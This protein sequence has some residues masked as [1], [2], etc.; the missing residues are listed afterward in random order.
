MEESL[1]TRAAAAYRAGDPAL[2]EKLARDACEADPQDE[3][4]ALLLSGL[5]LHRHEAREAAEFLRRLLSAGLASAAAKSNLALCYSRLGEHAEAADWARQACREKPSLVSAW[6][7]LGNALLA[8]G[9]PVAA[10][11]ELLQG[12]S[13]NPDHP[14]LILLLGHA[15]RVQGRETEAVSSYRRFEAAS[16]RL[17]EEAEAM[18]LSGRL[19]EAEHRYR[20]LVQAQPA[21]A[22]AHAGLGRALLRLDRTEEAVGALSRALKLQPNDPASRHFLRVARGEPAAGAEPAY[23]KSLFDS[24]ADKFDRSLVDDLGYRIPGE[25][26]EILRGCNGDLSEVVD[27][28]CGTGLVAKALAE[29]AVAIDGVDLS[30][31]ML[32]IARGSERYRNLFEADVVDFL[33][34]SATTYTTAIAADVLVYVGDLNPLLAALARRLR[35]GGCFAFSIELAEGDAWSLNAKTGRYQHSPAAVDVMLS[36]HGFAPAEWTITTIRS[37]LSARI[38]GAIGVCQRMPGEAGP[39]R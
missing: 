11:A 28:G 19:V 30:P 37:E 26:A 13:T 12:L 34:T 5:L 8:V 16:D 35:A 39:R 7:V 6:N 14:A 25:L 36:E 31:R 18:A 23:V 20:Q 3:S 9:D 4:A 15:R 17:L 1:S 10:E 33:Q 38:P 27:L 22:A 24:Y 21:N 29:D 2:A 32:A